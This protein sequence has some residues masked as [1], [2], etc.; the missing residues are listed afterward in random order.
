MITNKI[1][2]GLVFNNK[3][4]AV[5]FINKNILGGIFIKQSMNELI[6]ETPLERFTWIKPFSNF[7]GYRLNFVFTTKDIHNT[8]WFKEVI[9]PMLIAGTIIGEVEK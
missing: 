2:I 5:D 9:Y 8:D 7:K 3:N 4:D 6:Y 1:K